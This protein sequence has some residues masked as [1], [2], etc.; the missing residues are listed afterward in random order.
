MHA[1]RAWSSDP[2]VLLLGGYTA[3]GRDGFFKAS[4]FGGEIGYILVCLSDRTVYLASWRKVSA[5]K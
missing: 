4:F 2:C 1:Y 5:F 3:K